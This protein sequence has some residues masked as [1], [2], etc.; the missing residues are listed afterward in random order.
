MLRYLKRLAGFT[1][2][3]QRIRKGRNAGRNGF[4]VSSSGFLVRGAEEHETFGLLFIIYFLFWM[5]RSMKRLV[6]F[7]GVSATVSFNTLI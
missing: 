1:Q 5:P 7:L 3:T 2:R 4:L 6:G